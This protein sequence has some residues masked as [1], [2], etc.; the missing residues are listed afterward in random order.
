MYNGRLTCTLCG[1]VSVYVVR[2]PMT[3]LA[4]CNRSRSAYISVLG[5]A[6]GSVSASLVAPV[7]VMVLISVVCGGGTE[8]SVSC[9]RDV[10]T[11]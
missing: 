8:D 6:P 9:S 5:S 1:L 7:S 2:L 4:V 10:V 3:F 11:F